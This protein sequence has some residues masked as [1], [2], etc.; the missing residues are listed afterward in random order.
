LLIDAA[1]ASK[2]L[3]AKRSNAL[4][5]KLLTLTSRHQAENIKRDL[6]IDSLVK[7]ENEAAYITI[8]K[9]LTA[10]NTNRRVHFMYIEYTPK[11]EKIYKHGQRIY[12]FSPW[13][14]AWDN[15]RYYIIGFSKHHDKA[16]TFRVDRI[17]APKL[18]EIPSIPMPEDFNFSDFI[19][20]TF[21]MFEGPMLDVTLKCKNESMKSIIDRF[22]EY[23]ETSIADA[24][25]FYAKVKVSASK[26]F[27]GWVFASDGDI[28]ITAPDE[29]VKAYQDM[30]KRTI[31][32]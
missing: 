12:E 14:F 6:Y 26:T 16:I 20:T 29:A 11:K 7:P 8:D 13:S 3:T 22:G 31:Q 19:K 15:D 2:L 21:Q 27:Y 23:V 30:L 5:E 32:L 25:H 24:E 18:T 17:A 28:M 9:L 4:I 10:I 1:Q